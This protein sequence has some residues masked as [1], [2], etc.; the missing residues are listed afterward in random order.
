MKKLIGI[1]MLLML[2]F[3]WHTAKATADQIDYTGAPGTVKRIYLYLYTKIKDED[4][5]FTMHEAN[6]KPITDTYGSIGNEN[7][8]SLRLLA[9]AQVN[10]IVDNTY[11]AAGTILKVKCIFKTALATNVDTI[12]L[13][14]EFTTMGGGS[15][16]TAKELLYDKA[17]YFGLAPTASTTQAQL[18]TMID[19][20]RLALWNQLRTD[21]A[22]T[23]GGLPII[24]NIKSR[25]AAA[26]Q[27]IDNP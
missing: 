5:T 24:K 14:P 8:I 12:T 6:K 21:A 19:T 2:I 20:A 27:I 1:Y 13:P 22:A 7:T 26:Q 9:P 18:V 4:V 15:T 17:V 3:S 23:S 16:V 25:K 11:V 10:F